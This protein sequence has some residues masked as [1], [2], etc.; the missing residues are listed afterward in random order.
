MDHGQILLELTIRSDVSVSHQPLRVVQY[1]MDSSIVAYRFFWKLGQ[2]RS[3]IHVRS[4]PCSFLELSFSFA[5]FWISFHF[6]VVPDQKIWAFYKSK[7]HLLRFSL[8]SDFPR[9][10]FLPI[11]LLVS[12][13]DSTPR[14]SGL[15]T[16]IKANK[17]H[18]D[19]IFVIKA[20]AQASML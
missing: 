15:N 9:L 1:G 13:S 6:D 11:L 20:G 3:Q 12:N 17:E 10:F 4:F 16:E 7:L 14:L 5:L 18:R 2:V 19:T 8:P